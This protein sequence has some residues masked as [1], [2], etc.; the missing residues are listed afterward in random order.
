MRELESDDADLAVRPPGG[1]PQ[2]SGTYH[3]DGCIPAV[4]TVAV[5]RVP[6]AGVA[7]EEVVGDIRQLSRSVSVRSGGVVGGRRPG[8]PVAQST[9]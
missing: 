8:E 1:M 2:M 4:V 5:C 7:V 6:G 9:D 3:P